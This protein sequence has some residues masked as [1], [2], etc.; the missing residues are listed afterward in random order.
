M[1]SHQAHLRATP[2]GMDSVQK[3]RWVQLWQD[4]PLVMYHCRRMGHNAAVQQPHFP[5]WKQNLEP[6]KLTPGMLYRERQDQ[7]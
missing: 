1:S 2:A 7:D 4:A 6:P 5:Q 3:P